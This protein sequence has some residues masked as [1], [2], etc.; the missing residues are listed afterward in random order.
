MAKQPVERRAPWSKKQV[1]QA[2]TDL[3]DRGGIESLSM[4]KLSQELGGAPMSLYNHVADKEDLL[5]GI[6]DAL[7]TE[8]RATTDV[9]KRVA[10]YREMQ[11]RIADQ[12]YALFPAAIPLQFEIW[13]EKLHGYHTTPCAQ[14]VLLRQ[15]WLASGMR[16][17]VP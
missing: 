5:D 2:A 6:I 7:F 10:I 16:S 12:A 3:A 15:A 13:S 17:R 11:H 9:A 1:L 4:R 14:R 8:G